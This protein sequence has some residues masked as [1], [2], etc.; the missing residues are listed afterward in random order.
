MNLASYQLLQPAICAAY[1]HRRAAFYLLNKPKT[2]WR[3]GLNEE[4]L[5]MIRSVSFCYRRASVTLL[6]SWLYFMN[7]QFSLN[8]DFQSFSCS[9]DCN[10]FNSACTDNSSFRCSTSAYLMQKWLDFRMSCVLSPGHGAQRC[11]PVT[12]FPRILF[13]ASISQ[14]TILLS[15][16]SSSHLTQD[17][18]CPNDLLY[19]VCGLTFASSE[20]I[21]QKELKRAWLRWGSNSRTGD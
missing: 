13:C 10:V 18:R 21:Y 1:L 6:A 5:A 15:S 11:S 3:L 16:L 2:F 7:E 4:P 19:K 8:L 12:S 14:R 20:R 17:C 9:P